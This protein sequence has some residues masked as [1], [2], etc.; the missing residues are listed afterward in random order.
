MW[1]DGTYTMRVILT[2]GSILRNTTS[3]VFQVKKQALSSKRLQN[4]TW[5]S[6]FNNCKAPCQYLTPDSIDH[7]HLVFTLFHFFMIVPFYLWV[8]SYRGYS[9]HVK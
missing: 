1:I 8:V 9:S 2:K 7:G 4:N 6:P 3:S 5:S